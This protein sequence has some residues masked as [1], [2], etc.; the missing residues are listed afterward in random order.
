MKGMRSYIIEEYKLPLTADDI[1]FEVSGEVT[2]PDKFLEESLKK[3]ERQL[4]RN[5]QEFIYLPEWREI[6]LYLEKPED[7]YYDGKKLSLKFGINTCFESQALRKGL[8]K[9]PFIPVS[10]DGVL[11]SSDNKI[12]IGLRGGDVE[13]GKL[14][15]LPAGMTGYK[16]TYLINPLFDTFYD[17]LSSETGLSSNDITSS[18]FIGLQYDTISKGHSYVFKA[19]SNKT[20]DQIHE[21]WKQAEDSWEHSE[22]FPVGISSKEIYEFIRNPPHPILEE[23]SSILRMYLRSS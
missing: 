19:K 15:S 7:S 2:D 8:L 6:L 10:A 17:E 1:N 14:F 9:K 12:P 23:C 20:Y 16:S 11:I 13:K 4:G 18:S 21:S 22:L 5:R 3:L